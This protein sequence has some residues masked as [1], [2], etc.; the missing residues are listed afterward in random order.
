MN[1]ATPQELKQAARSES[2]QRRVAAQQQHVQQQIETREKAEAALAF[3]ALPETTQD[4]LKIDRAYLLK[5]AD[6]DIKKYRQYCS[7]YGFSQITTRLN[8]R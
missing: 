6:T 4:G 8:G 3:L 5:L 7:R 1:H 2:E